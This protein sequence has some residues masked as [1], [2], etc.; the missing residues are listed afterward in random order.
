M[1]SK[2]YFAALRRLLAF[3]ASKS[4]GFRYMFDA[5][6]FTITIQHDPDQPIEISHEEAQRL[7]Q[8]GNKFR[9]DVI[10]ELIH[11]EHKIERFIVG[12][13]CDDA[14][15]RDDLLWLILRH[16]SMNFRNK[17]RVLFSILKDAM[18]MDV[19][20]AQKNLEHLTEIRN[21]LAHGDLIYDVR[22]SD[23][24]ISY[25][26]G[27]NLK[28]LILTEALRA[29]LDAKVQNVDE[30]LNRLHPT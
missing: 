19:T 27:K 24:K 18:N 6:Y 26:E 14:R 15:K 5:S 4:L 21:R 1:D 30:Y 29:D 13:F 7:L 12:Y 11:L 25:R 3:V 9:G 8:A 16:R 28:F 20:A 10:N 23:L 17:V 22:K 2:A